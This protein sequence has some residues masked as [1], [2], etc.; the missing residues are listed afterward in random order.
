MIFSAYILSQKY[1]FYLF[2]NYFSTKNAK[3]MNEGFVWGLCYNLRNNFGCGW[4]KRRMSMKTFKL[5]SLEVVEDDLIVVV[6]LSDGLIINKENEHSTWL[7]EAYSEPFLYDYF[8]KIYDQK[9]ELIVQAVITKK[10]NDPA[11][12]QTKIS[13]LKK[14]KN[15]ISILFEGR[16]RRFRTDYSELLLD[17][18]IQKGLSGDLLLHE[19]KE[20]MKCKPRI[21]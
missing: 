10:E 15:H 4:K 8:K 17:S 6:P 9:R 7:L 20:K 2:V 5:V 21:K 13:S 16:L 3:G 14:F 19:F 1:D 18:L 11:Y 12:F